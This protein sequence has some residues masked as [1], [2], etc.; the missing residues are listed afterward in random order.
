MYKILLLLLIVPFCYATICDNPEPEW[1]WCD[2]FETGNY[3]SRYGDYDDGGDYQLSTDAYSGTYSYEMRYS[4]GQVDSGYL[5]WWFCDRWSGISEPCHDEIYYR[6]YHKYEAGFEGMPEKM[7]RTRR[8]PPNSWGDTIY[9]PMFWVIDD[10][11]VADIIAA[12]GW[13]PITYSSHDV[14]TTFG[15]WVC[16]EAYVRAGRNGA[17]T[18]WANDEVILD[19]PNVDFGT[20]DPLNEIM[21]DTYWNEGS[22]KAQSRFFDEFVISTERIGCDLGSGPECGDG[23]CDAGETNA[24]CPADCPTG[25]VCGDGTCDA[26]ETNANCPADCP[27]TGPV[28]DDGIC[29]VGECD[30]CPADCALADCCP[31]GACNNDETCET[32]EADCE[33]PIVCVHEADLPV[34]DGCVDTTELSAYI[35]LWKSGSVEMPELME[36]IGLWKE[37]C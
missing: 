35:D 22:P 20:N 7:A 13:L 12:G 29:D 19:K 25:S 14:T 31:D 3:Q 18:Y 10:H 1:L 26:G 11:V 27:V 24:N 5:G 16:Y 9:G 17:V 28:C 34:C 21:L 36:A 32:C 4:A 33:C 15:E 23:T 2:D 8:K 30:S 6:W 37:G